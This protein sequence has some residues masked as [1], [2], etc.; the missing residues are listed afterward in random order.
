METTTLHRVNA[1]PAP[2]WRRLRVNDAKVEIPERLSDARAT[3]VEADGRLF[4]E[5]DAFDAALEELQREVHGKTEEDGGREGY[6]VPSEV[7]EGID[8]SALS[9][10][11]ETS[12]RRE[13]LRSVSAAFETG[14]GPEAYGYLRTVSGTP[15][16]LATVPGQKDAV[17]SVRVEGVDG[18]AN[19]A[20]LDVVA[21]ADSDLTVHVNLD[22]PEAG[23]GV[24]GSSLRVFAGRGARVT[25]VSTQTLDDSW[26]ALDD[27]G[28]VLD[29]HARVDVRHTV[30]G[31]GRSYTGL[32]GDLRGEASR[33]AV[34]TRYL[35]HGRQERDFNYLLRHHGVATMSSMDANGVLS[36]ESEKTLRGT[37]DL[38][39]GCKGASGQETETVLLVDDHTTNRT[40][41]VILCGEDDVAGNHGATI[42]H[43]R[44]GQLFYLQSR[45]LS[46]E[47]SEQLFTR[48][49]VEEALITAPDAAARAGVTRLG[50]TLLEDFDEEVGA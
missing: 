6:S 14:M 44:P 33:V 31:A 15:T 29:A 50:K 17:A 49:T 28:M 41:P 25:I 4:G 40:V 21:A 48:A 32:A 18:G 20:A 24:V 13:A 34:D 10:F 27:T 39:R 45:G 2:T 11:Q 46:P 35:G 42:G 36:G 47:A 23:T 3:S 5:A 37:I 19:V 16:V 12:A 30:L 7:K 22:S 38:V 43:V 1:M 9:S 8:Q 26:I